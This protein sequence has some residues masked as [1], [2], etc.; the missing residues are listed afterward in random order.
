MIPLLLLKENENMFNTFFFFF[1]RFLVLDIYF[2][3]VIRGQELSITP[4]V[5]PTDLKF[6][7]VKPPLI[8]ITISYFLA[9]FITFS[10]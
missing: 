6:Y 8:L 4:N 1:Q 7:P 3:I 5:K 9:V 10:L 2:I